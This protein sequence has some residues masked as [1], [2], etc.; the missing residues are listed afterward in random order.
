MMFNLSAR[1]RLVAIE[2]TKRESPT[3]QNQSSLT[4]K[5][6]IARALF[7]AGAHR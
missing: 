6:V 2:T 7:F 3:A 5:S 4:V 1:R